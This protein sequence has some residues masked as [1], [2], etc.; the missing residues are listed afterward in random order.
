MS[1]TQQENK[2]KV[3]FD[4][5]V[6]KTKV[7]P[8]HGDAGFLPK[9]KKC[10][11]CGAELVIL[12]TLWIPSGFLSSW[13]R[14]DHGK[15]KKNPHVKWE[16]TTGMIPPEILD[17]IVDKIIFGKSSVTLKLEFLEEKKVQKSKG[18]VKQE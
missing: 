7:C 8:N 1:K 17:Q 14:K 12:R 6:R 16:V 11:L 2:K 10:S 18:N 15:D 5:I 3:N 13:H 4:D 9:D